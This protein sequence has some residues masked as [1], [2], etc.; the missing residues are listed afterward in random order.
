MRIQR[1]ASCLTVT[2]I[3]L[4]ALFLCSSGCSWAKKTRSEN[5]VPKYVVV[6]VYYLTDRNKTG[7]SYGGDRKYIVDCRHEMYYGTAYIPISNERARQPGETF[8]KLGWQPSEK[9]DGKICR[10]DEI[11]AAT[12]E[13]D[14]Q[15]FFKRLTEAL[16]QSGSDRLCLFVHG[17]AD[18]FEDAAEDAATLA[19]YMECP[20]IL[21][22][23]PSNGKLRKYRIDEGNVEWSQEHYNTFLKD[24]ETFSEHHPFKLSIVAHSVGNRLLARSAGVMRKS[25]RADFVTDVSLVSPDID[26]EIFKHYVMNFRA[27]GVKVRLFV[28]NRDKVLPFTQMLYGGY[29]RLGEGVGTMLAMVSQPQTSLDH[30]RQSIQKLKDGKGTPP[31]ERAAAQ[32]PAHLEKID[33]TALDARWIGH[34]FPFELVS[35]MIR[36]NQPGEGLALL[37]EQAGAGNKFARFARWLNDLPPTDETKPGYCKRVVRTDSLKGAEPPTAWKN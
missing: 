25:D 33:F 36:S 21:Y 31:A 1:F 24:L 22:S 26:A 8:T 20:T 34:H 13:A 28:S 15:E 35:N 29:Y 10:K 19:Y 17:A 23:W 5:G 12:A 18:P 30:A 11:M 16:K 4:A 9:I 37:P 3:V 14:K 7:K 27:H 2:V 6:P 32:P